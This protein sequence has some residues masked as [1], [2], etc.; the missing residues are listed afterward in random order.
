MTRIIVLVEG[1]TE[2]TFVNQVLAVDLY[3]FG[4]TSVDARMIGK[5][6]PRA[7]RG[8]IVPWPA[9]RKTI[10]DLLK[11]DA[12]RFVTTMVDYY[13]LLQDWPG[14]AE[15]SSQVFLTRA[16]T[17]ESALSADIE[18][19]MGASF[20]PGRF[21]PYVMMHEFEAMLFSDCERFSRG[22]GHVELAPRFQTIRSEFASPEEIDDS[23][24][25]APS[26]RIQKLVT[27]YQK[28][29]DG[30]IAVQEI[31]LDAI[32]GE[33]AHFREWLER[34]EELPSLTS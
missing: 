34:L 3:G 21:V 4:Y 6:R 23:P 17:V 9:M 19:V 15:S 18:K 22:I 29:V 12:G 2:E 25:T 31:G 20:N 28:R 13:G 16:Y 1:Q 26:K 14:R 32:R 11:E 33:C 27:D 7:R 8:G 30:L 24:N 10:T 5:A